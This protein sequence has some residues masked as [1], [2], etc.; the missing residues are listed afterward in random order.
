M[1]IRVYLFFLAIWII[2]NGR[3]TV[4]ILIF[5]IFLSGLLY[6]FIC[7]YMD[8][9]PKTEW[10][11]IR[12]CGKG[13]RYLFL[14]IREIIKANVQV[15]HYIF[16]LKE[17]VEPAIITFKTDLKTENAKV[18]LAN[19]ITLTPGTITVSLKDNT[20]EVHC[21]DKELSEGIEDSC[22]VKLL[23]EMEEES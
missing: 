23:K 13:I 12:K 15:L 8:Y 19:S 18:A 1:V 6:W 11:R 16:T 21:L 4:E 7:K 2:F 9:N 3:I 14:L 20:Y 10:K 22:F 17:E 5:G